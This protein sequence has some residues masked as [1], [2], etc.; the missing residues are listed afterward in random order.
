ME[1][2]NQAKQQT[3]LIPLFI[4]DPELKAAYGFLMKARL[5]GRAKQNSVIRARDLLR[6]PPRPENFV[7]R[8]SPRAA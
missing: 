7:P 6:L 3:D 8:G 4:A 1:L 2:Q 5:T